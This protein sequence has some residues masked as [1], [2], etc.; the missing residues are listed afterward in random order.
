MS[1]RKRRSAAGKRNR[2]PP[3]QEAA[4]PYRPD[5]DDTPVGRENHARHDPPRPNRWLLVVA[6]LMQVVW[7]GFL[8][9]M[10]LAGRDWLR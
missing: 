10:A 5:N 1:R 3:R 6:V 2:R 9:V 7:S 8:V 4:D